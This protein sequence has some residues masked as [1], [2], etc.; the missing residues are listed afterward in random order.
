M[1]QKSLVQVRYSTRAFPLRL[2]NVPLA[3]NFIC[4]MSSRQDASYSSICFSGIKQRVSATSTHSTMASRRRATRSEA[5]A[6]SGPA[7]VHCRVLLRRVFFLNV[8]KSRYVSV[9]FYPPSEYQPLV[10]F[11]GAWFLPLVLPTGCVNN[12]VERLPGLVEA[13]CRNE[14][15]VWSSED[16]DFKIHTTKAYRTARFSH[17]K[18]WISYLIHITYNYKRIGYLHWSVARCSRLCKRRNGLVR[19]HWAAYHDIKMNHLPPAVWWTE[20]AYVLT[21]FISI[22]FTLTHSCV[23]LPYPTLIHKE[24]SEQTIDTAHMYKL[25]SP[26]C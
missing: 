12:V 2:A 23:F 7:F 15:F 3:E 18:H 22:N 9:G 25:T 14:Q 10:E 6:Y 4:Y 19:L 5:S 11:G 1:S 16:K 17:D 13:M 8:E 26:S 20:I 24:H 21:R